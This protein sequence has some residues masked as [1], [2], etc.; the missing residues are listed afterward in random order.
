MLCDEFLL[1]LEVPTHWLLA[2]WRSTCSRFYTCISFN[3]LLCLLLLFDCLL[4]LNLLGLSGLFSRT[5]LFL[6]LG[7]AWGSKSL[8]S[9]SVCF[10]FVI[11]GRHW[12][13]LD[14]GLLHDTVVV[15]SIERG[16]ECWHIL[17]AYLEPAAVTY[18]ICEVVNAYIAK[19]VTIHIFKDALTI[20]LELVTLFNHL[21]V[22]LD[23]KFKECLELLKPGTL[24]ELS[25]L[26][27]QV[28][29]S[30]L[31]ATN[32]SQWLQPYYPFL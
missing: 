11:V 7:T 24:E 13:C 12:D 26:N 4:G 2:Q 32:G 31:S 9:G 20:N 28:R 22:G 10:F 29:R 30:G 25:L 15:A 5:L 6:S 23:N 3:F 14:E 1:C 21:N 18:P 27:R 19:V 17:I 8:V 16:L